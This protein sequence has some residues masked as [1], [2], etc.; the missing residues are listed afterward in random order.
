MI[1][2]IGMLNN[3]LCKLHNGIYIIDNFYENYIKLKN[4]ISKNS[5]KYKYHEGDFAHLYTWKNDGSHVTYDIDTDSNLV[6]DYCNFLKFNIDHIFSTNVK[7]K[8]SLDAIIYP[9]GGRKG[10]HTDSFHKDE[11]G[12]LHKIHIYSSAHFLEKP[13]IGGELYYPEFDIKIESK[14]NRIVFFKCEYL[15]EVL[16][17]TAGNK[18]SVNYFWEVL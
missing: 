16:E 5:D 18:I 14:E 4:I 8:Y 15:H 10:Q 3:N 17:I 9:V 2:E 12:K 11:D 13:K 7:N 1:N 6:S